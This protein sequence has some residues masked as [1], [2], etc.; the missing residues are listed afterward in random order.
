[1]MLNFHAMVESQY[2]KQVKI[3]QSDNGIE[4]PCMKNY[5]LEQGIVFQCSCVKTPHQNCRVERKHK[6]ILNIERVLRF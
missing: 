5:F 4:F 1:M 2:H 6:H 3:I